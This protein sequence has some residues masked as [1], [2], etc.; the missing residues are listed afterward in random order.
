MDSASEDGRPDGRS[1]G[2]AILLVDDDPIVARAIEIALRLAGHRTEIAASPQEAFSRLAREHYDA[3][4]LDM[5]FGPGKSDGAEGLAC[6]ARILADDPAACVV[7]ITAHSGIRI[8]VA[9]MQ[10]GARDFAMKPWRN[11][12]LVGKVEAA[13]ARTGS[14]ATPAPTYRATGAPRL[15]GESAAMQTLRALIRRVAPSSAGIIVTGPSGAGR[16]LAA[17]AI[18]AASADAGTPL[19]R[20]D[21]RDQAAWRQLRGATGTVLL[22]Y[23][24]QLDTLTQAR[25]VERLP[26]G[27][28]CLAVAD[29]VAPLS[30]ALRRRI[31]I[32]EVPVPP[33]AARGDD[34]LLLARHFADDAAQRFGRPPATLT[35]A[36][37]AAIRTAIWPDEVRGLALGIERAVLLSEDGRI[38]AAALALPTPAADAAVAQDA[39]FDL[40]D[41]ERAVIGAALR[42]YR[43]NV[44]RAATALGL[45]RGALYRRMARYGL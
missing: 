9:A 36:A 30:P 26:P 17:M 28:R 8:A 22:R 32:V 31:A 12:E 5:N 2:S 13:I 35:G 37:E 10:A 1:S 25:L 41:A 38:D 6:L 11:A 29:T 15:L 40:D 43:H 16:T 33:L 19:L 34:S 23:P 18:H 14:A 27:L 3:I 24:D 21:L 45:S 42:E 39:S 4:L 7:V 20:V 44:T